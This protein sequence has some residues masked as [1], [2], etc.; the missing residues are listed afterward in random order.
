MFYH[1][2]FVGILNKLFAESTNRVETQF[3]SI[4]SG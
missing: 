3:E 4:R 2:L 1:N